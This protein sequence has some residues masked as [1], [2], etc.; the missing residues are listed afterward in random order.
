MREAQP[1]Y[2]RIGGRYVGGRRPDPRIAARIEQALGAA[3]SV[4]NVAGWSRWSPR[5]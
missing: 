1:L 2:D 3:A 4:V 5:R